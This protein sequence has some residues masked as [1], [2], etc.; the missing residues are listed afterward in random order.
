MPHRAAAWIY[1]HALLLLWRGVP[2]RSH[3]KSAP[4]GYADAKAHASLRAAKAGRAA[5]PAA[6]RQAAEGPCPFA[7]RDATEYPWDR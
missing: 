6:T 7:W 1:W 3:P 2:F 5:C 4:G